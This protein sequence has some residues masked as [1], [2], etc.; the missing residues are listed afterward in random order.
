MNCEQSKSFISCGCWSPVRVSF[1]NT[2]F[3]IYMNW[4]DKLIRTDECVTIGRCKT[5]R[6]LF[7]DNLVL[8]NSSES[9]FQQ[10]LN[11][12]AAVCNFARMKISNSKTELLHLLRIPV[13]CYIQIGGVSLK[14]M[15]KFK[16]VKIDFT[17][18]VMEGRTKNWTFDQAKQ[19][20]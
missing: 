2:L 14:H 12:F 15:Q 11:C 5:S 13:Q 1:F 9:G 19:V 16:Y 20:L 7:A 18:L 17:S 4:M 6:L 3:V 10:A 8:L